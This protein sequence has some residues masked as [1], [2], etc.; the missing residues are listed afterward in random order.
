VVREEW[1]WGDELH[2][3]DGAA[4]IIR[5]PATGKAVHSEHHV[6]K[7]SLYQKPSDPSMG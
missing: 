6:S 3:T 2:R 1:Y 7:V 4:L 5:N